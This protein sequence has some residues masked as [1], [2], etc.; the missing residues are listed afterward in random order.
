[1]NKAQLIKEY[2]ALPVNSKKFDNK[3]K[4]YLSLWDVKKKS[5]KDYVC[6]TICKKCGKEKDF[7]KIKNVKT[8]FLEEF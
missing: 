6:V 5:G 4:K 2:K 8:I 7:E 1:M 3:R